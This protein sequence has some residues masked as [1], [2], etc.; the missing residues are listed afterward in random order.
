MASIALVIGIYQYTTR[1]VKH[2][3]N[4]SMVGEEVMLNTREVVNA[5]TGVPKHNL[6]VGQ[7]GQV[8]QVGVP[9]Y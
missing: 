1:T 5:P 7:A 4:V 2:V 6:V 8:G 3:D 9:L